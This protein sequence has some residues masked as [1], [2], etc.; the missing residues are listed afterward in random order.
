MSTVT[1]AG[2]CGVPCASTGLPRLIDA[3]KIPV[4][5]RS[6]AISAFMKPSVLAD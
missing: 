2:A 5:A 6:A 1:P 3:R 4:G